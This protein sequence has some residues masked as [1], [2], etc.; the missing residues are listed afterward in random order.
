MVLAKEGPEKGLTPLI[1]C[2]FNALI[3][4]LV[5]LLEVLGILGFNSTFVFYFI[6]FLMIGWGVS[7]AISGGDLGST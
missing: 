3:Y 7:A 4:F 1:T 5:W 2:G 6:Y